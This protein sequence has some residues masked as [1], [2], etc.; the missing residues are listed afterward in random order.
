[1][2]SSLGFLFAS[3]IPDLLQKKLV[4]RNTNGT[5]KK[6][7]IK[8]SLLSPKAKDRE[9]AAK[10]DRKLSGN[11]HSTSARHL[12]KNCGPNLTSTTRGT[13]GNLDFQLVSLY[14]GPHTPSRMVLEKV[15]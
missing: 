15:K 14:E 1:M 4:N 3:Y 2:V 11:N 7:P 13:V 6:T 10:Q 9:A 8:K 5:D 12:R